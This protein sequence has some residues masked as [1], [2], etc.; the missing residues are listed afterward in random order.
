MTQS[1]V[2]P[3]CDTYY[4][5]RQR[6]YLQDGFTFAYPHYS[7][8]IQPQ[9]PY[10]TGIPLHQNHY[11]H[12]PHMMAAQDPNEMDDFQ[13][14]SDNYRADLPVRNSLQYLLER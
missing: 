13:R 10:S 4:N 12:A 2:Y 14:L 5:F 1:V 6:S 11:R 7:P 9:S 8:H 3:M